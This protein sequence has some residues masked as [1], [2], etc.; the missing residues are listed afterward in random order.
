MNALANQSW[1]WRRWSVYVALI[2]A[3]QFVLIYFLSKRIPGGTSSQLS[4]FHFEIF[5]QPVSEKQL[6][7]MYLDSDPTLFA[8]PSLSGFSGKAWLET[9]ARNYNLAEHTQPPFWLALDPRRLGNAVVQFSRTNISSA[10]GLA[11]NPRP[12]IVILQNLDLEN[13]VRTNSVFRME[14]E[15]AS[16]PLLGQPILKSWPGTELLNPSITQIAVAKNGTVVSTRLIARSGSAEAD[17][18]ALEISRQLEFAPSRTETVWGNVI[19]DWNTIPVAPTNSP[20]TTRRLNDMSAALMLFV[21][22]ASLLVLICAAAIYSEMRSRKFRPE[23]SQDHIFRCE[24][25]NFVYTDD[26]DVARSRCSQC[27]A[28]NDAIEF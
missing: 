11:G 21:Y 13:G 28:M 2:F 17:R 15:I 25:C 23:R 12:T 27:G 9:P 10:L 1:C 7:E 8:L 5:P 20:A 14:G 22:V 19:F 6:A 4:D 24:K 26:A 16:R 3:I 18:A